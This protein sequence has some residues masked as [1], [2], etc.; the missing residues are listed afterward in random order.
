[1]HWMLSW[2]QNRENL[3]SVAQLTMTTS[4]CHVMTNRH[5][6]V[7]LPSHS[8][9]IYKTVKTK[10]GLNRNI[11]NFCCCFFVRL[12]LGIQSDFSFLKCY[13]V[14]INMALVTFLVKAEPIQCFT[15]IRKQTFLFISLP[16]FP[17]QERTMRRVYTC[18]TSHDNSTTNLPQKVG[19]GLRGAC[20]S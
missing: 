9:I 14:S 4:T 11:A 8:P 1:M 2:M 6:I 12:I 16:K 19:H 18:S 3:A 15:F 7:T 10:K 5:C 17:F 20:L 13:F